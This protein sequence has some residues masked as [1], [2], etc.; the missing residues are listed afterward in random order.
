MNDSTLTTARTATHDG[1]RMAMDPLLSG[2]AAYA[3]ESISL[4]QLPD[5]HRKLIVFGP[6]C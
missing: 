1:H 2:T 5:I 3:C 4:F 6:V